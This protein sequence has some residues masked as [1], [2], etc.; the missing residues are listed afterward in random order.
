MSISLSQPSSETPANPTRQQLDELD[1]LLKRMLDLPVN[2]LD[3]ADAGRAAPPPPVSYTAAD[4]AEPPSADEP[5]APK[6]DFQALKERLAAEQELANAP[7]A[8]ADG[9]NDNWVPLSSTWQPSALTWKPLARSWQQSEG[10]APAEIAEPPAKELPVWE[11]V[12]PAATEAAAVPTDAFQVLKEP[13][14]PHPDTI[15]LADE[16]GGRWA[17]PLVWFNSAFDLCLTPLGP[18]GD[19]LRS[20][21][22]RLSLAV[23]GLGCLVAAAVVLVIDWIGWPS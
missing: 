6:I 8:D 14:R 21:T 11:P 5:P 23:L 2:K 20:R 19:F 16:Q 3:D 4:E 22:G 7:E 17:K 10:A 1:A 15:D 18:V 9:G 12:A 13:R